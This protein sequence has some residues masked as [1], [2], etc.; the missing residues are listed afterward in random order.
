MADGPLGVPVNVFSLVHLLFVVIW[1]PFPVELPVTGTNMNCA[2]PV[3]SA[4][5][6]GVLTDWVISGRRRFQVPAAR[7]LPELD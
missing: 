3:F 6:I 4:I 7:S 5:L 2:A 1:M